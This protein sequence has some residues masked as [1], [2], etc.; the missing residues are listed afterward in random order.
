MKSQDRQFV[1][2]R[3]LEALLFYMVLALLCALLKVATPLF[4]TDSW[5]EILFIIPAGATVVA[6]LHS[7]LVRW[8]LNRIRR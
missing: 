4:R 5:A 8:I 7:I 1:I 2:R 6:L 3:A